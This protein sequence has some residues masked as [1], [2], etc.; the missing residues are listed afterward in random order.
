MKKT[1][2]ILF[3]LFTVLPLQAIAYNKIY[4]FDA[5]EDVI[6]TTS[7]YNVTGTQCNNCTCNLTVFNPSPN[8]NI[9]NTSVL[10]TNK[11]NG[12]YSTNLSTDT[13]LPYN[14]NIY[15]ITLVCN[16]TQG[17]FGGDDR[18]G[19]KIGATLFDYTSIIVAL[20]GIAVALMFASFK[21]S[22]QFRDLQIVTLFGS[23]AFYVGA[24]FTGL[25]I[26]KL[27]P[28]NSNLIIIYETMFIAI[29]LLVLAFTWLR[30][31]HLMRDN[32]KPNSTR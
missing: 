10:L 4:E 29:S 32:V 30:V 28:N 9:I 21:I 2:L 27:S 3:I 16:D 7:V 19:I 23:F 8:E 31:A 15:P 14:E 24:V 17:F 11:G 25:E 6:I 20:I 12:I 18:L 1:L 5:N 13:T 22:P 26:V